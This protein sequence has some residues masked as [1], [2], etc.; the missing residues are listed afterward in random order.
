[1]SKKNSPSLRSA[2]A[3]RLYNVHANHTYKNRFEPN[4]Y[5]Q[6]IV[7][8]GSI[9]QILTYCGI[10]LPNT[11]QSHVIRLIGRFDVVD[12]TASSPLSR[13]TEPGSLKWPRE[14]CFQKCSSA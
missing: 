14:E 10:C 7:L 1:M 6:A 4:L 3:G 8:T 2:M 11:S 12:Q 9:F 5:A 13:V